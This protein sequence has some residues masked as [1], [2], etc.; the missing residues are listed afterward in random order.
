[1]TRRIDLIDSLFPARGGTSPW[2]V[3]MA[4]VFAAW[5]FLGDWILPKP[6]DLRNMYVWLMMAHERGLGSVYQWTDAEVE[7]KFIA[8]NAEY[9]PLVFAGYY[10]AQWLPD[11][12]TQPWPST[13]VKTFFRLP[14][15][16]AQL[17]LTY[18]ILK[19]LAARA[20]NRKLA[21]AFGLLVLNPALFLLGTTIGQ[22]DILLSLLLYT[23]LDLFHRGSP[24]A[25]GLISAVAFLLKPTSLHLFPLMA[26]L[27][28]KKREGLLEWGTVFFAAVAVFTLPWTLSTGFAW[29]TQGFRLAL[30][31]D[32]LQP[33]PTAFNLWWLA[34]TL[35]GYGTREFPAILTLIGTAVF[36]LC[37]IFPLRAF[38]QSAGT[39]ADWLRFAAQYFL[40]YFLICTNV[41]DK[42]LAYAMVFTCL[43]AIEDESCLCSALALIPLA[44]AGLLRN[45]TG[46]GQG[47]FAELLGGRAGA[48]LGALCCMGTL[49]VFLRLASKGEPR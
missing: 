1:M 47:R 19:P 8:K 27:L 10:F 29:F 9:P 15:L 21:L 46:A 20:P 41:N 12:W 25:S 42:H 28:W 18:L 23:A 32:Y 35:F 4:L 36:L 49:A 7:A 24:K 3:L 37:L 48:A 40:L 34:M 44:I 11:F 38:A 2:F 16:A 39:R 17:G 14:S 5:F 22:Y 45:S 31:P 30:N 26:V 33:S 13:L 6:E 43:L